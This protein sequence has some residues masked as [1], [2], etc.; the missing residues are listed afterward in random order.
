MGMH[1]VQLIKKTLFCRDLGLTMLFK[2]V[3]NS[4]V[5]AILVPQLPKVL[6]LQVVSLLLPRLECS[7]T[8]SAHCNL[9]P[10]GSSD[11]PA[12]ASQIVGI[13][14]TSHRTQQHAFLF[15]CLYTWNPGFPDARASAV[16]LSTRKSCCVAQ[17]RVQWCAHCNLRL[18]SSPASVSGVAGITGTC[19]RAWLIFVLLVETGFTILAKLS[20]TLSSRLECSGTISAHCNLCLP[21]SSDSPATASRV[22]GITSTH[23]HIQL[24]FF[25]FVLVEMGF[26]HVAQARF[27][28]L[29]SS[30]L[31]ISRFQTDELKKIEKFNVIF[32]PRIYVEN[33]N[34]NAFTR[35]NTNM[36]YFIKEVRCG[37]LL[38]VPL[39]GTFTL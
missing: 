19:H 21:S 2:L 11:S 3:S 4:W 39:F 27:E 6:R 9:R 37:W 36:Q 24:I 12:T 18:P 8:I 16:S 17:A 25:F 34:Q 33:Q 13:T 28:L 31:P 15:L 38:P 5:Q 1:H 22:A 32:F 20:L 23:D 14:G 26:H 29:T 7:G 30:D 10:L 35:T